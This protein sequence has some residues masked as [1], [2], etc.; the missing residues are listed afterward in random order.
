M[1]VGDALA[2]GG[3]VADEPDRRTIMPLVSVVSEFPFKVAVMI[4]L[5]NVPTIRSDVNWLP[6]SSA[7]KLAL[8]TVPVNTI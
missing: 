6:C 3:K 5:V 7:V 4:S 8:E 1:G 2:T